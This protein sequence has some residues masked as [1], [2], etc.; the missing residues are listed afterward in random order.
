[1]S[2]KTKAG[3][4]VQN[5]EAK[6]Q[7]S[8]SKAKLQ[9]S[10]KTLV[11]K[12]P[13]PITNYVLGL[14][15]AETWDAILS[16]TFRVKISPTMACAEEKKYSSDDRK[17]PSKVNV[18]IFEGPSVQ[19]LLDYYIYND[20]EE[21]LAWNYFPSIDK[22]NT[23]KD[24]RD[25]DTTDEDCIHK[26]NYAMSKVSQAPLIQPY[27]KSFRASDFYAVYM[28]QLMSSVFNVV[29][30]Q[31][32]KAFEWEFKEIPNIYRSGKVGYTFIVNLL[33][34]VRN[35]NGHHGD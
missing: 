23:D 20:I 19:G 16:K 2:T 21:Y 6:L 22:E 5:Q 9:R 24:I 10:P 7:T 15:N 14:A 8:R 25:K 28:E 11:V 32:L 3:Y 26:C 18:H 35:N 31:S 33:I 27:S 12:S 17:G 4:G 13:V 34:T 1:M 29:K 30:S